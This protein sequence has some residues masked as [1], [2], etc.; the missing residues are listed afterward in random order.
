MDYDA[1]FYGT[2]FLN[3]GF[4]QGIRLGTLDRRRASA[5]V[6][7]GDFTVGIEEEFFLAHL[8]TLEVALETPDELFDQTDGIDREF[9]Q[10]Q[11]EIGTAPHARLSEAA[12][13]LRQLRRTAADAAAE[14]G[15]AIMAAGT[16]PTARWRQ[17]AQSEKDR[18][19]AVME[20]LRMI[21]QRNMLCGMHVHVALP[22]PERRVEVMS[23][24]VPYLPLLLALS[25]S[26]PFWQSRE[27]G[28]KGYRLAAYDELPRTGLPELFRTE[29][30]YEAYVAALVRSGVMPDSSYIW[31][32]IRP[33]AKYP[34]L[35]LRAPDSCT[36]VEDAVAIAALYRVL[37]RHLYRWPDKHAD[38]T[39]VERAIAVENKWRAQ[40]YGVQGSFATADG[41]VPVGDMLDQ[42]MAATEADA[43]A[44]GCAAELEHCRTIVRDGTSADMQLRLYHAALPQSG[45]D[46]AL[47]EVKRW[48]AAA[49]LGSVRAAERAAAQALRE[50][51][52]CAGG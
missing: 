44:L 18:Y 45:H 43:D 46:A 22:D 42:V 10:A 50:A 24:M 34:T 29:A 8:R 31:W 26:S 36:R 7:P 14:H 38:L 47:R 1:R 15:L 23:R 20:D 28:L 48:I 35:E 49:T 39:A 3:L 30:E 51:G 5:A 4:P 17:V 21:G 25:T 37:T 13:E 16:H 27:T 32:A 41:P 40:R 6:R 33:S 11:V 52:P 9:L 19:D 12:E 2:T